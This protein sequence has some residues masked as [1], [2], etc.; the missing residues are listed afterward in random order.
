MSCEGLTSGSWCREHV[1]G[2]AL[3]VCQNVLKEGFAKYYADSLRNAEA[4]QDMEAALFALRYGNALRKTIGLQFALFYGRVP[5]EMFL[6]D[7]IL[8]LTE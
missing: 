8:K 6:A 3:D 5:H 7:F 4:W 1:L 2:D